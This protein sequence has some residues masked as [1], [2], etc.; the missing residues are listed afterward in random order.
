MVVTSLNVQVHYRS[1]EL[2]DWKATSVKFEVLPRV[3][4]YL[5]LEGSDNWF[6]VEIVLHL[7]NNSEF[8]AVL[9][10]VDAGSAF[11]KFL[12]AESEAALN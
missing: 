7:T 8:D 6:R 12:G 5:A 1:S 10:V 4:E 9:Y 11:C 2:W 3:G